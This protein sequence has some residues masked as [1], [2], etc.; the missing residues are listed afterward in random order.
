MNCNISAETL[1]S[2]AC[3]FGMNK[4]VLLLSAAVHSVLFLPSAG[5]MDLY[6]VKGFPTIM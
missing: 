2:L 6:G 4:I 1:H 5:I 3:K